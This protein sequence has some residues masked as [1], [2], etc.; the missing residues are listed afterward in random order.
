MRSLN[1]II[2]IQEINLLNS[3]SKFRIAHDRT[4]IHY[5]KWY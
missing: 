3:T 5:G 2:S 1:R 4:S